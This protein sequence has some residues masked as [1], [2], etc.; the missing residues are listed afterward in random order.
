MK[1]YTTMGELMKVAQIK[2]D[3]HEKMIIWYNHLKK[4]LRQDWNWKKKTDKVLSNIP[5]EIY[6]L[7]TFN[8]HRRKDPNPNQ[9]EID[10]I[11]DVTQFYFQNYQD[12]NEGYKIDKRR[13][14]SLFEYIFTAF[15]IHLSN[16]W[17][18]SLSDVHESF[19][20]FTPQD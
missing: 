17:S 13:C 2:M 3:C 10:Y 8:A 16:N 6:I 4:E 20:N 12:V 18:M 7:M 15:D 9:V 14:K 5:F 11:D 1:N 19:K